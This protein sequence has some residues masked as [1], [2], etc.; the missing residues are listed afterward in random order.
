M[1]LILLSVYFAMRRSFRLALGAIGFASLHRRRFLPAA[2]EMI[3]KLLSMCRKLNKCPTGEKCQLPQL[4][5]KNK[6]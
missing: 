4:K 1:D 6:T 2:L 5:R 3:E